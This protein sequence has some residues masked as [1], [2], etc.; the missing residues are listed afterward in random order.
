VPLEV[1][2]SSGLYYTRQAYLDDNGAG[3]SDWANTWNVSII[4][5]NV[6]VADE[7]GNSS[8]ERIKKDL[9]VTNSA[10]DLDTLLGLEVTNY[11]FRD[12]IR[13]G[14]QPHKKL[15]A[16]QVESV[17][18]Q[19]VNQTFGVV[20]DIYKKATVKDG[21]IELATDLKVGDRVKLISQK[22]EA[23]HEVLEVSEGAFRPD[24]NVDAD[25]VFVYGREVNDF[26]TVDYDAI[27][28]LNVSATQEIKREKDAEIDAL[29]TKNAE[30]EARLSA[31]E[32]RFAAK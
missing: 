32:K 30:L 11:H 26:R 19:A 29:K 24:G 25:S 27:A 22:E 2:G 8:D 20:P 21:W 23:V 3:G 13:K 14:T 7:F 6:V 12:S 4:A 31:L 9:K 15:I 18:P 10:L 1:S 16:Q 28:M 5:S 17:Y